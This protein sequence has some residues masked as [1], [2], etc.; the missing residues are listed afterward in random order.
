PP[1]PNFSYPVVSPTPRPLWRGAM[2]RLRWEF[3]FTY[4]GLDWLV[5]LFHLGSAPGASHCRRVYACLVRPPLAE[6][7]L[8]PDYREVHRRP[9]N[10]IGSPPSGSRRRSAAS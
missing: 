9:T 6:R 2:S 4:S 10:N 7:L 3:L 8:Q 1:F 5:I